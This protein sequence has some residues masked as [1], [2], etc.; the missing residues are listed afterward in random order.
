[1]N[2]QMCGSWEAPTGNPR[3]GTHALSKGYYHR[4][5]AA[6]ILII[7]LLEMLKFSQIVICKEEEIFV[8]GNTE[9]SR[10]F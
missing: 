1:M 4:T 3:I 8:N 2:L 5:F 10:I 7:L 9:S 6:F